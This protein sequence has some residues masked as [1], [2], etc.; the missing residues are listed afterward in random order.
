MVEAR[1]TATM[2][3]KVAFVCAGNAGRSQ[4]ASA[5]AEREIERRGLE[6][7]VVTGGV[8]PSDSVHEE[9]VAA[10]REV[11]VDISDR[12]PRQIQPADVAD[13]EYVV[14]MGCSVDEFRPPDWQGTE[15]QWDL[16]HPSAGDL[17]SARAQRDEIQ[18]RVEEFLD[19]I[20]G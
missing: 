9:V 6:V 15:E 11:D 20:A 8:D 13:A 4:F 7:E 10:L 1:E 16:E 5:L 2:V 14:T 17:E 12:T 19:R 18:Q 3:S